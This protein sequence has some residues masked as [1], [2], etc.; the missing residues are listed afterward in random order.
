MR[1]QI[2]K[3]L[4][5]IAGDDRKGRNVARDDG[6]GGDDN[7]SGRTACSAMKSR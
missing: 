2:T 4:R 6:T 3:N 1:F 7:D 5:R